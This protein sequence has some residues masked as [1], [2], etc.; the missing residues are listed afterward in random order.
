MG[1]A[2]AYDSGSQGTQC[3]A[4]VAAMIACNASTRSAP[5]VVALLPALAS[6]CGDSTSPRSIVPSSGHRMELSPHVTSVP[7]VHVITVP[8]A[9]QNHTTAKQTNLVV[10]RTSLFWCGPEQAGLG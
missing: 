3:G 2:F 10:I 9:P 6:T 8:I 5:V 7:A 4:P 1:T